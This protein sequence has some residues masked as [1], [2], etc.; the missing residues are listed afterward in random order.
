MRSCHFVAEVTFNDS[1]S[2]VGAHIIFLVDNHLNC[3]PFTWQSKKIK[4]IV[5]STIASEALSL[6]EAIE[7][8]IFLRSLIEELLLLPLKSIPIDAIIDNI[9]VVEAIHSTKVV[10]DRRLNIDISAIKQPLQSTEIHS[11]RWCP[12]SLQLANSLTKRGAQ[13]HILL[14]ILQFGRL[15]LEG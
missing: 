12:G 10:N 7:H 9:S 13:S 1:V 3:C 14:D 2:S 8:A 5:C 11:I 6:Q 15:N 4:R